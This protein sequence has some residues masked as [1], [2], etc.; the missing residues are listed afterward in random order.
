MS[1][2]KNA[3]P[4][5]MSFEEVLLENKIGALQKRIEQLQA[6]LNAPQQQDS[7]DAEYYETYLQAEGSKP[8]PQASKLF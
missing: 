1:K 8:A 2:L 3:T 4:A 7:R 5:K 6:L